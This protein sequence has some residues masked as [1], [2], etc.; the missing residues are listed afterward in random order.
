MGETQTTLMAARAPFIERNRA[1][2]VDFFEDWQ[3][4]TR[5][6]LDPRN[7]AEALAVLA[8]FT[9]QP[10]SVYA[11]W[12]FTRRDYYRDPEVRPNLKALQS[13]LAV[14]K[15]LGFLKA[16]IDVGRYADLSLVEEAAKRAK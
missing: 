7:R 8:R 12:A 3:R 4:A 16:D 11:D 13:N 10:E 1:A 14:Q 6:F 9:R 2:L 15:Q 5:W